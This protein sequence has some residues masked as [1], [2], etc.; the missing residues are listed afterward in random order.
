MKPKIA[1][2]GPGRVGCSVSKRLY[3]AGYPLTSIIGRNQKRATEACSYIGCSATLASRQL[4]DAATADIILLAVPDDQIRKLAVQIQTISPSTKS[5]T[6]IHFSGLHP[7]KIMYHQSSPWRLLSL[8]PLL[9]F[10]DRQ[11]AY[12]DLQGCPCALES[13]NPKA[14]VIGK[15][16][17]NAMGGDSFTI[18]PGK[19]SLYHSAACIA[20]NYLVT[21]FA[22]ARELLIS[23]GI[24][25]DRA[26]PL[27]LPLVQASVENIK[28]LGPEQGLT[29][30]IVRGDIETVTEHLQTLQDNAPE[31]LQSY[32][33]LGI[34]TVE[35]SKNAA[36]LDSKTAI[37]MQD[38]L[39]TKIRELDEKK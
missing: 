19:K 22:S 34:M 36:R 2:I 29:G 30:P 32:L 16:L 18:D 33:Q 27:L 15:E 23:S 11:K 7:A 20:S 25:P 8:H 37:A 31:L 17:V 28:N 13:D 5:R 38:L 24:E 4:T 9:P 10:A 6:L 12:V 21:L 3:D 39:L 14:L 35:I 1:L 26:T